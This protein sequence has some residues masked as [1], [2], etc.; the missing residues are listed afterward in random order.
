[1]TDAA[2]LLLMTTGPTRVPAQV[3]R[4]GSR[5]MIHHRTPEFSSEL[6]MMLEL[7]PPLFGTREPVLPIHATGRGALEATIAN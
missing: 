6:A 2:P 1:V 7:L 4:A 5:P 3:L